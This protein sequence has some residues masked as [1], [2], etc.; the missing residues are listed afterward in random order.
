LLAV[1]VLERTVEAVQVV[2]ALQQEHQAQTHL[3][4]QLY[5]CKQKLTI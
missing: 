5:L 3:L 1:V 2:I 4:N